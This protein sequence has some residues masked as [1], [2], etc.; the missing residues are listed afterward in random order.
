MESINQSV[1]EKA[2]DYRVRYGFKTPYAIHLAT[3]KEIG[4]NQ[5]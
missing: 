1:I 3:A 5:G 2:L 4:Q